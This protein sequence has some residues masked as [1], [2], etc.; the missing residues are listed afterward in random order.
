LGAIVGRIWAKLTRT[1]LT[2]EADGLKSRS[3]ARASA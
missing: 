3:E 1:Y 2:M